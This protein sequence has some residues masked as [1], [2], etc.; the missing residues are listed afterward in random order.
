MQDDALLPL[1][2]PTTVQDDALLPLGGPATVQ[3][4]ALLPL[5]LQPD[6]DMTPMLKQ[7]I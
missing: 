7:T 5:P 1:G 2:A 6:I 4:D 3:D